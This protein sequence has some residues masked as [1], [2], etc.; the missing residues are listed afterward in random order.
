MPMTRGMESA[1]YVKLAGGATAADLRMHLQA[2]ARAGMRE[3][4]RATLLPGVKLWSPHPSDELPPL[5]SASRGGARTSGF[6]LAFTSTPTH[7]PLSCTTGAV[8]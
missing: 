7:L 3:C 2:S 6:T 8:P 4:V 5:G 1:C